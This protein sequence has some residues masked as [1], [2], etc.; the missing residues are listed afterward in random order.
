MLLKHFKLDAQPFGV[1]PDPRFLYFGPSHREAMASL[2]HGI[3]SG[4]GFTALIAEPGMGKTTLLFNLLHMLKGSAKTAFLF[5]T[6][7]GPREFM[8]ALLVDLGIEESSN[9]ITRMHAKLNEYLLQESQQGSQLVLVIDE[10]Q[11][12]NE[13]TLE[14]LRML[15][16][17][18]T[19]DKKLMQVV[20]A[21]QPQLSEKLA[22]DN[23]SQLRQ[24]ISIIAR[25]A[26][27]NPEDTRAYIEHRLR[28]AGFV[29]GEPLFTNRA[30]ARIAEYSR[31]IPRNINNLCFNAMSLGCAMNQVSL[32]ASII[33]EVV[34]DLE[35]E[36][37][38]RSLWP[39]KKIVS[40]EANRQ[41][42]PFVKSESPL[43][44]PEEKRRNS[45]VAALMES[46]AYR[47]IEFA[48]TQMWPGWQREAQSTSVQSGTHELVAQKGNP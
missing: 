22:S 28:V 47:A 2:V 40:R 46:P 42:L 38:V 37:P 20:L 24:R 29:S 10:A 14:V 39:S 6:L 11:N 32:D 15:S 33:Q 5:Q 34:Q 9:V 26:A 45:L 1:T 44:Y 30:Y 7:C 27:F 8:R 23:L 16:N 41:A 25:L 48:R 43:S 4:R 35:L 18:E 31:G 17:F 12:L 3:V 36:K 19:S 13:R 21:G